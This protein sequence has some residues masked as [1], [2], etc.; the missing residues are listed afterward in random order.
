M[1]KQ[2]IKVWTVR[3]ALLLLGLVVLAALALW[4]FLRGSLA[5]L[6][7]SLPTPGLAADVTV[8]RDAHGVPM[9][10]GRDRN[11]IAYATGYLHAQERFFQMD[12][13]RRS[14][15]GELAELFGPKAVPLDRAHRL[16]RFRARAEAALR[17]M[18]VEQRR[19]IERYVAGVNAGLH[20]LSARPFEYA[21]AGA[22]P[23]DWNAADSLL[24]VY[25]MYLDLQDNL[26]AR[27]LARGWLRE[28]S[29]PEQLA[30]LL[31]EASSW[32]A[33]L[34]ADAVHVP[35]LA[36][37]ARAPD[38]WGRPA[39]ASST[40][41][42]S[43]DI[44]DAV[45][46]NNWAVAGSRSASGAAIVSND[47][48]L[49]LR[50]PNIWYRIATRYPGADG[51]PRRTVGVTLPGAPPVAVAGS[52]GHVAWGYTNSYGD[53]LDLIR[54][55]SDPA[56]AGQ[57]RTPAGWET[58]VEQR[59]TILVKGAPAERM[60]VRETRYGP[61]F[62]AGG[63]A[64]ALH[65]VAH[66]PGAVNFNLRHIE[67]ANTVEEALKAANTLGIPGQNFMVGDD[68][69]NIG[70]TIAGLLP[71]RA[72]PGFASSYPVA[73]DGDTF[74]EVLDPAAYP[75]VINPAGGQLSTANIRQLDGAGQFLIGDG[76]FDIGARNRQI[77]DALGALGP[78]ATPRDVYAVTLDD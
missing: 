36:I 7:G 14:G 27:E 24:V 76:G 28:H 34:D 65:W 9:I 15:A 2:G 54:V 62:E 5:R 66:L 39:V 50:L 16:H 52:N 13:M 4:L 78:R 18:D 29:T 3:I 23:R 58:P 72:Q 12:L 20:D 48:H 70:W 8:E 1:A 63:T 17:D 64:Y 40:R 43:R 67:S 59:E 61:L 55:E 38:W 21:L 32:D 33:P 46:S 22:A 19:L 11:D 6:D 30:I 71:R 10:S 31:P 60:V 53:F 42:A 47:M 37:P 57:V 35:A 41:I 75:R 49:G 69:G 74:T 68:Q 77:R 44:V 51:S 45:G 25:A 56:K 26:A 73:A